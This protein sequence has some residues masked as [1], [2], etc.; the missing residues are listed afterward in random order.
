MVTSAT[1]PWHGGKK[2]AQLYRWIIGL[3]PPRFDLYVEPFSGMLGVL[4]HRLASKCEIA[5][6]TNS[7]V[8]NWWLQARDN[9]EEMADKLHWTPLSSELHQEYYDTIDEGTPLE[10]A[11]KF[12][13]VLDMGRMPTDNTT[14]HP[15][16][17]FAPRLDGRATFHNRAERLVALR[18][19]I[20]N[21][22]ILNW[23]A[24]RVLRL[25][26]DRKDAV[27]YCDPPYH[28]AP[29][30]R[31]RVYTEQEVDWE[32]LKE[33]L[34]AQKGAVAISGYGDEY[35]SLGWNRHEL[36]V[37]FSE[38]IAGKSASPRTEVLWTN[39]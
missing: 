27:I 3:L 14:R 17:G 1:P 35:D 2:R 22:R 30:I 12:Q 4:T 5:S 32:A 33:M 25:I 36:E 13:V 9:A 39:Y 20:A 11:V 38:G 21:L 15:G 23:D 37:A 29:T 19:R 18:D 16:S 8:V 6:D 7:R 24:V 31:R 34:Q 28:S 26:R 10:R